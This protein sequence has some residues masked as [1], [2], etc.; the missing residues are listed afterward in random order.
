MEKLKDEETKAKDLLEEKM[1][2]TSLLNQNNEDLSE[3][4][5]MSQKSREEIIKL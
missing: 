4:K 1:R 3:A 5:A 2:Q